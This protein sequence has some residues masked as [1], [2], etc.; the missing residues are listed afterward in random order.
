MRAGRLAPVLALTLAALPAPAAPPVAGARGQDARVP[1]F[2]AAAELVQIDVVVTGR[3]G[4]PV[5]DLRREDF[6]ILEDARPQSISHFAVGTASRPAAAPGRLT[7]AVTP[8]PEPVPSTSPPV[9]GRTI[10]LVF[11]DL[12]LA[13][14]RLSAAKREA[15]RFLREQVGPRDQVA[16]VTTSGVRGVFQPLTR[17]RGALV[18]A[19]DRITLQDRGSRMRFGSPY[20]SEHQAEQIERFGELASAGNEA[21]E[22]AVAQFMDEF[23]VGRGAA[24]PMVRERV[25]S[26]LDEGARYTRA[27]LS[28]LETTVRSLAPVPGRKVVLLLSE[29]FFL[30]RGT[31]SESAYDLR[32]ITDAATRSGVVVYSIDTSGLT[33]PAPAGDVTERGPTDFAVRSRVEIGQDQ[34]RREGMRAVAEETGG[35]AVLDHNDIGKGLKRIL[36]DNEVY[37]LLAYEPVSPRRAGRFRSLQVRLPAR[38]DLVA[39]TRRGYFEPRGASPAR[40]RQAPSPQQ[41]AAASRERVR[42]AFTSVVPLRGLPIHLSADFIDLPDAGPTVVVNVGV[43]VA[44]LPLQEVQE[45]HRGTVEIAGLV[46]D[47]DGRGVDQFAQRLQLDLRP[48]TR[49]QVRRDGMGFNRRVCLKPGL[50][51]VRVAALGDGPDEI[52]SASRWIEVPD[53]GKRQLALSSLFLSRARGDSGEPREG[54]DPGAGGMVRARRRFPPGSDIDVVLFAYNARAGAAGLPDL[55]LR[56]QLRS[57]GRLIHEFLPRPVR[58]ADTGSSERVPCGVQLSLAGLPPGEYELRAIV[59]DRGHEATAERSADF[60]VE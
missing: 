26:M 2:P 27:S 21:F 39:R 16:V 20:I 11:D 25:R 7:A 17:D 47:G 53:L 56:L 19:V 41:A 30:G 32:R 37:Y 3:D 51:Q 28:L 10:V 22:L 15:T 59:E 52:G 24:I 49:D 60:T 36:D 14:S 23:R 38:P 29:G 18:R 6:E 50:Y 44:S 48:E 12:H 33:V 8:R 4:V 35:F 34:S 55:A 46:S 13:A 43:D 57:E 45:R 40:R 9:V 58:P 54:G 31:F 5:R 42:D 1:T